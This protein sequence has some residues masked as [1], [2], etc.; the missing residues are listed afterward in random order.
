[1]ALTASLML[2]YCLSRGGGKRE[3]E[4]ANAWPALYQTPPP[5]MCCRRRPAAGAKFACRA[6]PTG[7]HLV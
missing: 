5:P 7:L 3:D 4:D 1:M 6:L 2:L